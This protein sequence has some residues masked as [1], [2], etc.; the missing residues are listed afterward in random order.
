MPKFINP[1]TDIGFKKI[2]GQE[3]SKDLLLDFLNNLLKGERVIKDLQFL[4][5]E[6]LPDEADKRTIIY[7]IFC[8]TDTGEHILVEMQHNFQ[9]YFKD[10]AIYYLSRAI[11]QQGE[12]GNEWKY[13][14]SAVYGIFF[15]DFELNN[16]GEKFRTDIALMDMESHEQ[17]SDKM[18]MVFLELPLFK[19]EITQCTNDF[20]R[21]IYVLNNMSTMDRMPFEAKSAVFKKLAEIGDLSKL[22]GE[23]R[24]K[25]DHALRIY[26]DRLAY[27]DAVEQGKLDARKAGLEEGLA[28]GMERGIA[29][30]MEK[31]SYTR[32]LSIA[33]NLKSLGM[34]L[35]DISKATGLSI[36]EIEKI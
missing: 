1:F 32:A 4:D 14:I 6:Q 29:K 33:L 34:S 25:Y 27:D 22:T 30:G 17:F 2:F 18:R 24:M 13:K 10:R 7:D 36:E 3:I 12:K 35:E 20:E 16:I 5:K 8:K 21:W 19:K 15:M 28:K 11:S 9:S 23:E 31:G 26:R